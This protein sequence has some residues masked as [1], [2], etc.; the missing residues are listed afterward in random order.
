MRKHISNPCW[1]PTYQIQW[2]CS[3]RIACPRSQK[4]EILPAMPIKW[5][6]WPKNTTHITLDKINT[7]IFK[8]CRKTIILD[9]HSYSCKRHVHPRPCG[10]TESIFGVPASGKTEQWVPQLFATL[11]TPP[12]ISLKNV[13]AKLSIYMIFYTRLNYL[14]SFSY[15]TVITSEL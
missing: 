6:P 11:L 2:G 3:L 8:S 10:Y 15:Y 9:L 12:P 4:T 13:S 14:V 5:F 1:L 7:Y